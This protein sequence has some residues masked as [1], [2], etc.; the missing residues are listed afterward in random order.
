MNN[1]APEAG[2]VKLERMSDFF[3]KRLDGYEEH[4]LTD[5]GKKAYKK[6]AALVP[7]NTARILDLGCGTGLELDEIFKRLPSVSVVGID[8]TQAML[9][10]LKQKHLDKDIQ[11][12][13]GNYFNVDLG[14]NTFD[15][16]ISFQSMHHFSYVEKVGL[17]TKIRK[18]LKSNGVYIECDYMVTEQSIEDELYA[19][20]ARLRLDMNIPQGKFYHFDTPC[21]VDNQI[22]MLKQAGFSS[23]D[24]V[25]RMENTT[26]IVAKK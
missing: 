15:T 13:C 21:T 19:E 17:Y 8:M 2:H 6:L 12:I 7:S 1:D 25:F 24:P 16:A 9:D 11:L 23:A 22:A 18:A 20:N 14:E 3:S 26:I 10:K 5:S 4:M